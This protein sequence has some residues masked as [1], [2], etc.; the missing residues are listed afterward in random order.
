[1]KLRELTVLSLIALYSTWANTRPA[2]IR[3]SSLL[4][5]PELRR[6]RQVKRALRENTGGRMNMTA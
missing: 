5:V 2:V 1:M 3:R 4:Y 6:G